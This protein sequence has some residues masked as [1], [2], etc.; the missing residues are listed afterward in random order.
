MM[1]SM[2]VASMTVTMSSE[3]STMTVTFVIISDG[4]FFTI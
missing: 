3:V 2:S 4:H 1:V